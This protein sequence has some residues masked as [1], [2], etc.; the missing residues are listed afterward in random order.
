MRLRVY[1]GSD[2]EDD[3][4]I[5]RELRWEDGTPAELEDYKRLQH[6]TQS[7]FET[8]DGLMTVIDPDVF[9][10][11]RYDAS[12]RRWFLEAPEGAPFYLRETD[13]GVSDEV[14][15]R[16]IASYSV[17]IE[18]LIDRSHLQETALDK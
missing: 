14:L 18:H 7:S 5:P 9:A 12:R 15:D 11:A 6:A 3:C 13:P 4:Q 1:W 2:D 16:E 17:Q 10:V 8:E